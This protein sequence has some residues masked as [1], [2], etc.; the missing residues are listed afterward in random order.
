MSQ[1]GVEDRVRL[2]LVDP[3][4]L[5]R[6]LEHVLDEE[7]AAEPARRALGVQAPSASTRSSCTRTT[8]SSRSTTSPAESTTRALRRQLELA[9]AGVVPAQLPADRGAAEAPL[10]SRRRLQ[11]RMPDGL[12]ARV[13]AVGGDDRADAPPDRRCSRATRRPPAGQRR[14][15][16]VPERPA[17][18]RPDPVPRVL[19]RR[20]RRAGSAR[21]TRPAGPG[22]VAKLIQQYAEYALQGRADGPRR[23]DRTR[24]SG[25]VP[26]RRHERRPPPDAEWLEADGLGRLRIGHRGRLSHAALPRAA[27]AARPRRRPDASCSSTASKRG[28]SWRAAP[29][30][31]P[32]STTRRT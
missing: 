26:S 6:M 29:C 3:H 32:R 7:G 21:A 25:H 23:R 18:A 15:R 12:G 31:C 8:S 13:H 16:Q 30:R 10:L 9:R 17:L 11:G 22:V 14:P 5:E 28:S 20:H 2:A 27:A 24:Q 4:K 1:R 19:P